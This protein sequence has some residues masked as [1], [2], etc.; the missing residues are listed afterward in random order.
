MP[1][2]GHLDDL[3]VAR[4]V[5]AIVQRVDGQAV[6]H[7]AAGEDFV[8]DVAQGQH[9]PAE[10]ALRVNSLLLLDMGTVLIRK[11]RH[12]TQWV[13]VTLLRLRGWSGFMPR[14]TARPAA[15]T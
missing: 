8:G 7:G 9:R 3:A 10:G 2:A 13:R 15:M 14:A 1:G 6:A 12:A 4:C 11:S 5:Q